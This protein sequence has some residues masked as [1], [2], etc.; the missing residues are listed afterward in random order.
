[1]FKWFSSLNPDLLTLVTWGFNPDSINSGSCWPF[2]SVSWWWLA[3]VWKTTITRSVVWGDQVNSF[4]TG[5][6]FVSNVTILQKFW[7]CFWTLFLLLNSHFLFFNTLMYIDFK[8]I[9]KSSC[10]KFTFTVYP[11]Y[12]FVLMQF[13]FFIFTDKK[14]LGIKFFLCV[15]LIHS[16]IFRWTTVHIQQWAYHVHNDNVWTVCMSLIQINY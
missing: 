3:E 6:P 16:F 15:I 8:L 1:M 13:T 11:Y 9:A 7:V 10:L 12:I 5:L 4:M 2:N 14:K